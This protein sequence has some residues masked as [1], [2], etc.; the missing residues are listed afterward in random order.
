MPGG[1]F[2]LRSRIDILYI[3]K[4]L[5]EAQGK[6]KA[7]IWLWFYLEVIVVVAYKLGYYRCR[8]DLENTLNKFTPH[9]SKYEIF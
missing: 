6:E 7:M 1:L 9:R 4:V 5:V 3:V 8:K 2:I